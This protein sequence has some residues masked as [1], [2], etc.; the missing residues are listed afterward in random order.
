MAG[1]C[2]DCNQCTETMAT[3]TVMLLPR[4]VW[5]GLTA[6]NLG[7]FTKRCPQCKHLMS[8]HQRKDDGSFKD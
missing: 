4:L 8:K 7:L 3:S 5:W 6:W 2:R 1:G